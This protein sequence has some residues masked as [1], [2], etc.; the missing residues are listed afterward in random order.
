M[1]TLALP[2][3]VAVLRRRSFNAKSAKDRHDSAYFAWEVSVRLGA[4]LAAISDPHVLA[5][6]GMGAWA[7][8]VAASKD[9]YQEP[10]LRA[11]AVLLGQEGRGAPIPLR[12]TSARAILDALP[13]YRNRVVA[14]GSV[15]ERAF[16]ARAGDVLLAALDEAW[17]HGFFWPPKTQLVFVES[18]EVAA[19]GVHRG[20]VFDMTGEAPLLRDPQGT[21]VPEAVRAG[22]LHALHGERWTPLH[23]WLLHL[24]HSGRERVLCFD[25]IERGR[26]RYLDYASG[27]TLSGSMLEQLF[28]G[29]SSQVQDALA[30]AKIEEATE[31][32]DSDGGQRFGDFRI[33]GKL[34]Q[35]AMGVVYL[36]RQ[37]SLGRLTA[38]K[39]LPPDTASDDIAVARFQRE[40]EAISRCEHPNIVNILTYGEVDGTH[41][42]AMEYVEGAPL[43]AVVQ[44]LSTTPDVS[45]AIS[46][47]SERIRSEHKELFEDLPDASSE[48]PQAL[49][50]RDRHRDLAALIRDAALGLHQLHEAGVIHRDIKPDNIM[51]T[52]RDHR[53]VVMDLGLAKL[54]DA[55]RSL[56]QAGGSIL[57]T[58]RYMPPEQL[59]MDLVDIDRRADVYALGATLYELLT[60]KLLFDGETMPRLIEQVLRDRAPSARASGVPQDLSAIVSK[61]TEK[62]PRDRYA[63]AALLAEDLDAFLDG[64]PVSARAPTLGYVLGLTMKRHPWRAAAVAAAVL[65]LI[66]GTAWFVNNQREARLREQG[67]RAAAEDSLRRADELNEFMLLDLG[68]DLRQFGRLRLLS[69]AANKAKAYYDTLPSEE[70]PWRSLRGRG[71]TYLQ[72]HEVFYA[73][74]DIE[75]ALETATLAAEIFERR[76]KA[77]P[78]DTEAAIR[79]AFALIDQSDVAYRQRDMGKAK[80]LLDR[81]LAILTPIVQRE[82]VPDAGRTTL[83]MTYASLADV[84]EMAEDMKSALRWYRKADETMRPL[85]ERAAPDPRHLT[86]AGHCALDIG[87]VLNQDGRGAGRQDYERAL[88]LGERVLAETEGSARALNLVR[89]AAGA[90]ADTVFKLDRDFDA[91]EKLYQR[92]LGISQELS[93]RDPSRLTWQYQISGTFASLAHVDRMRKDLDGAIARMI[94]ARDV[95]ARILARNPDEVSALRETMHR[96]YDIGRMSR[97]AGKLDQ[98]DTHILRQQE[99]L[100]DLIA[101]GDDTTYMRYGLYHSLKERARILQ[102]MEKHDASYE[103]MRDALGRIKALREINAERADWAFSHCHT[104]MAVGKE[105]DDRQENDAAD[106]MFAEALDV[107]TP[108]TEG[109][110]VNPRAV[111]MLGEVQQYQGRRR[112]EEKD[113]AGARALI[114]RAMGLLEPMAEKFPSV[115]RVLE[116]AR[117]WRER[118]GHA[119]RVQPFLEGTA[120]AKSDDEHESL[121]RYF[122]S[123][124]VFDEPVWVPLARAYQQLMPPTRSEPH[125]GISMARAV[126]VANNAARD[127]ASERAAWIDTG[128]AWL[129]LHLEDQRAHEDFEAYLEAVAGGDPPLETLRKD[130]RFAQI[131]ASYE[132][133]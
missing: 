54:T 72:L 79:W 10:A 5:A 95:A 15:R 113:F 55:S 43:S 110:N 99:L 106:R 44:A 42:Y 112:Y 6:K 30:G 83:A 46:S 35:G 68:D 80:A 84:A 36:A 53:A 13:A 47:A 8:A 24:D 129:K 19:G 103:V 12:Q 25:S 62:D 89:R 125:S 1:N 132:G 126:V 119:V 87:V 77:D 76:A 86:Q 78:G 51:V 118:I 56:T 124:T 23:P 117:E 107:I 59:Q 38:L 2:F 123:R 71:L 16:Y 98:A 22:R 102:E 31:S 69:K 3:P 120:Q 116:P 111:L 121:V 21:V 50:G 109:A 60:G 91:A 9:T 32:V 58:L 7:R 64:R 29:V 11:V 26:A 39:M 127:S 52:A 61:A 66:G 67:L 131:L 14:H 108:H 88:A 57:G 18:V 20:R 85:V 90:L 81:S 105:A 100:K 82:D 63:S 130:S 49:T 75:S 122:E 45:S 33:L 74:G 128:M 94:Q 133:D 40:V 73:D 65:A 27:E 92:A 101:R 48:A 93:A 104:L 70:L 4:M 41:Y 37:E 97:L 96:E 17:A 34:G 115:E 28:P 114:D